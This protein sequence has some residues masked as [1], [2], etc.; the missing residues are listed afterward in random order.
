MR[1]GHK[2]AEDSEVDMYTML[3]PAK[4]DILYNDVKTNT[5]KLKY[6]LS[7]RD[8]FTYDEELGPNSFAPQSILT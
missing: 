4:E 3:V 7:A 5:H 6:V 8:Y 1:N 2:I